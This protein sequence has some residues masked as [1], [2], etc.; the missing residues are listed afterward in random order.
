MIHPK[1]PYRIVDQASILTRLPSWPDG[2]D[3]VKPFICVENYR[4]YYRVY[5]EY[6]ECKCSRCGC[7]LQGRMTMGRPGD[8]YCPPCGLR[9]MVV[10]WQGDTD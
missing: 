7:D 6:S 1:R 2:S 9:E 10:E 8:D 3:P 5:R 4:G